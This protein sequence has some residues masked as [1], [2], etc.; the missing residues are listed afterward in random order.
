MHRLS[1][2]SLLWACRLNHGLTENLFNE[3]QGRQTWSQPTHTKVGGAEKPD[4]VD[5]HPKTRFM[6]FVSS[7]KYMVR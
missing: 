7:R 3:G 1:N 6:C 2:L 4:S 5:H